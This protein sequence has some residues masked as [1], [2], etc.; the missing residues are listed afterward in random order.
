MCKKI[1]REHCNLTQE[2]SAVQWSA[3]QRSAV[4]SNEKRRAVTA[5]WG[6]ERAKATCECA[7]VRSPDGLRKEPSAHCSLR[8]SPSR[9]TTQRTVI[10]LLFWI[11]P[12][13]IW[14]IQCSYK[15]ST[16]NV[17][18]RGGKVWQ[19]YNEIA[20]TEDHSEDLSEGPTSR[21]TEI[22]IT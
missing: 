12:I 7:C 17:L 8:A 5:T 18:I 2:W 9:T 11:R 14:K 16:V 1:T 20:G 3:V 10:M 21:G 13:R 15:H 22:C 19:Y 6:C 4:Q